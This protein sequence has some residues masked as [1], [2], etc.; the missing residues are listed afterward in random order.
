[1][2]N[3]FLRNDG[4]NIIF[5]GYY[6]EI[7]IPET[8]FETTVAEIEGSTVKTFGIVQCMVRDKN[9]KIIV[10]ETLNL[11]TNIVLNFSDI[12]KTK[13]NLYG[14]EGSEAETYR[15]LKLYNNDVVMANAVNKNSRNSEKFVKLMIAGKIKNIDYDKLL[16]LWHKN[17]TMN[18]V[19]LNV[20]STILELIISETYRNPRDPNEKFSKYINRNPKVSRIHYRSANVREICSRNSTFSAITFE[21]FDRMMTSSLNMNKYNKNQVESPIEKVIKM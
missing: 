6:M 12:Y 18:S 21:D 14:Y 1:M 4:K 5:T 11:P 16:Q 19:N 2:L 20:P 9:D 7:Y 13:I 10:N 8:Y 3:N 15:V 17:L